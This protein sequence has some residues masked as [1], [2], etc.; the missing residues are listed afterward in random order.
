MRLVLTYGLLVYCCLAQ[1]NPVETIQE[2]REVM[3]VRQIETS[4]RFTLM[5]ETRVGERS[6]AGGKIH[7][8]ALGGE[9]LLSV[10]GTL[11]YYGGNGAIHDG[12]WRSEVLGHAGV[13]EATIIPDPVAF[14][15]GFPRVAKVEMRVEGAYFESGN[16]CGADAAGAKAAWRRGIE[17]ALAD[18]DEAIRLAE[19]LDERQ[20]LKALNAGLIKAGP[21]A[22]TTSELMNG[23]FRSELLASPTL[24][25]KDY[26]IR[27]RQLRNAVDSPAKAATTPRRGA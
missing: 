17:S 7:A 6:A 14:P 26:K 18:V 9:K 1:V 4:C 13:T 3:H 5:G 23:T 25:L 12:R 11:R 2:K 10:R 21:Y 15:Q 27:L 16:S 8:R 24:L 20:F 22:R 19:S